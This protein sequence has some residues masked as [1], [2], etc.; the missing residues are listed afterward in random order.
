MVAGPVSV[1]MADCIIGLNF[2][3]PF[4]FPALY[5]VI[6]HFLPEEIK[7]IFSPLHFGFGHVI[8]FGQENEAE[9]SQ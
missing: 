7:S 3:T 1:R 2:F 5:H 9:M 8:C 6:F 4:L